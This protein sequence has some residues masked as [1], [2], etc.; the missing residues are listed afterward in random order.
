MSYHFKGYRKFMAHLKEQKAESKQ[1][2]NAAE[3]NLRTLYHMSVNDEASPA[4][5]FKQY[6]QTMALC[7]LCDSK[8][9]DQEVM[10]KYHKQVNA[11]TG[12]YIMSRRLVA[13]SIKKDKVPD[14]QLYKI[15]QVVLHDIVEK[16]NGLVLRDIT[17]DN[18]GKSVHPAP[19]NLN[20]GDIESIKLDL[21]YGVKHSNA[22]YIGA[23]LENDASLPL[24]V[25]LWFKSKY[26]DELNQ[27]KSI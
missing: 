26:K 18:L 25:K 16:N 10:Q 15:F 12:A 1:M 24:D 7:S 6:P 9:Y 4:Q 21:E 14:G 19:S 3:S 2:Q 11:L 13:G 8:H 17:K 27:A 20:R 5:M 23:Q 22:K